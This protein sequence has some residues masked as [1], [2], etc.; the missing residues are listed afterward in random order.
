D[1]ARAI[2]AVSSGTSG[3]GRGCIDMTTP[4]C[5]QARE[6]GG[7]TKIMDQRRGVIREAPQRVTNKPAE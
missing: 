4:F 6:E 2:R 1:D 5:G 3:Q 7:R